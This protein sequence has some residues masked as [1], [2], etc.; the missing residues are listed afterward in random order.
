VRAG[1]GVEFWI[2]YESSF[3]GRLQRLLCDLTLFTPMGA[4]VI[5]QSSAFYAEPLRDLPPS[6]IVVCRLPSV[7]L[8]E[9]T[10]RC[11]LALYPM[12]RRQHAYDELRKVAELRVISS[13]YFG[14]GKLPRLI[15]GDGP[16]LV[17]GEWRQ[18]AGTPAE[19]A[20]AQA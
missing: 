12:L 14:G 16:F 15:R 4:P 9:G 18:E 11:D 13:D 5:T 6:G 8:A 3:P 2:H 1:E 20:P 19:P 10:Y 7:P 17:R